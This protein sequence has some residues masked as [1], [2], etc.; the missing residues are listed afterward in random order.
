MLGSSPF[1]SD[2]TDM[3]FSSEEESSGDARLVRVKDQ[4][5]HPQ[6]V[7][8]EIHSVPVEGIIDSGADITIIGGGLFRKL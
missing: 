7:K 2:I 8:V 5:S 4:G 1:C 6:Y 3:L